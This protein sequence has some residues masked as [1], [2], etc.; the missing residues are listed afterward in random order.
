VIRLLQ[1]NM[2]CLNDLRINA[3]IIQ[4]WNAYCEGVT[5]PMLNWDENKKY[6]AI[7]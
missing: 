4:A 6:P 3:L 5:L 2:G 1:Q 7:Q